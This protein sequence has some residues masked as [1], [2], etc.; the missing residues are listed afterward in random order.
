MQRRRSPPITTASSR[1][2]AMRKRRR[3]GGH[4]AE[5]SDAQETTGT[6]STR[7]RRTGFWGVRKA[8]P[9]SAT[10]PPQYRTWW[11][12]S[13]HRASSRGAAPRT[14]WTSPSGTGKTGVSRTRMTSPKPSPPC[15][16][17]RQAPG[18]ATRSST[19]APTASLST[20]TPRSASGSS[21]K[22]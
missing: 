21:K 5:P 1:S 20:A 4:S 22:P 18:R 7:A 8:R 19:L 15:I 11:S 16:R 10:V 13:R 17:P 3:A 12:T 6:T 2:T 14:R 9:G